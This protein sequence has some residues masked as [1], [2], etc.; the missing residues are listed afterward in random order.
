MRIRLFH[1]KK[2]PV[3][4][5]IDFS[6]LATK[7]DVARIVDEQLNKPKLT[8]EQILTRLTPR[9]REKLEKIL[10]RRKEQKECK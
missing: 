7:E 4:T 9:Q 6:T 8:R 1:K 3:V 10:E 2:K 5:P